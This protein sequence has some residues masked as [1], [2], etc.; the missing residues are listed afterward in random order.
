MKRDQ[1]RSPG[2]RGIVLVAVLSLLVLAV[3]GVAWAALRHEGRPEYRAPAVA[4]LDKLS[5]AKIAYADRDLVRAE[6]LLRELTPAGGGD[7]DTKLF[8]GRVLLDLGRLTE[9]RGI[10]AGIIKVDPKN[11][12]A[13]HGLG[14]AYIGL[15]QLDF[16]IIHLQKAVVL[17]KDDPGLWEVWKELALAQKAAGDFLGSLTSVQQSLKLQPAQEDLSALMSELATGRLRP[18]AIPGLAGQDSI[19]PWSPGDNRPPNPSNLIPRPPDP[20]QYF[21]KP[22]RRR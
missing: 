14:T 18:D 21:P 9:A 1:S 5:Q 12:P 20:N 7:L 15:G 11:F 16:G 4:R 6:E 3:G 22:N 8:L 19:R 10:F 2:S 13:M 17:G